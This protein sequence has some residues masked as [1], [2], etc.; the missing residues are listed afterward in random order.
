[1]KQLVVALAL[2]LLFPPLSLHAAGGA[3]FAISPTNLTV[4][5]G[6]RFSV[7]VRVNPNGEDLDTV[8]LRLEFPADVVR[9]EDVTLGSLFPRMSPGNSIDNENGSVSWGGFLIGGTVTASGTFAT[10]TFSALTKGEATLDILDSSRLISNGEEKANAAGHTDATVTIATAAE[11]E[12][13]APTV[14]V[15]SSTH[16]DE[17]AWKNVNDVS[18]EWTASGSVSAYLVAF[19]AEPDT[20]PTESVSGSVTSKGYEDVADGIWYFHLKAR[21]ATGVDSETSHFRVRIDT[22]AP[23]TIA[24]Y[25]MRERYLEGESALVEFGTTDDLSG[26][27]HYE[28]SIND[29]SF[30]TKTSPVVLSDLAVGDLFVEVK[31]VD[32]AGNTRFGK[33]G[34]RV[35][36]EGTALK[37]EDIAARGEEEKRI[38]ELQEKE[39]GV[40]PSNATL[41]ITSLLALVV[42][43]GIITAILKKRRKL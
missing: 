3:T 14:S 40:E 26:I 36:P 17:G 32:R 35:Y 16:P 34:L 10:I 27:D 38:E 8:R 1:M 12:E 20:E 2:V 21:T 11:E 42:A 25:T 33:T 22:T 5:A 37:P 9:V 39:T 6:E 13:G 24:P 43:A 31:A 15:R 23:N 19:D 28:I 7:D 18:F 41:L 4:L 29:S 30:E